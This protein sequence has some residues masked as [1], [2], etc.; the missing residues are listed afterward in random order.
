MQNDFSGFCLSFF[1]LLIDLLVDPIA[2]KKRSSTQA[3]KAVTDVGPKGVD[4]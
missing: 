3:G 2:G 1:A 4:F